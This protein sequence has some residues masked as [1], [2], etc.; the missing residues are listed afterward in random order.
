MV[1]LLRGPTTREAELQRDDA[2][3]TIEE[4]AID[5][6]AAEGD[7][8]GE[9]SL[10]IHASSFRVVAAVPQCWRWRPPGPLCVPPLGFLSHT[11]PLI[12]KS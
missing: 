9:G 6:P 5:D 2:E 1:W 12:I 3:D 4:D 7:T 10:R 8:D 11:T